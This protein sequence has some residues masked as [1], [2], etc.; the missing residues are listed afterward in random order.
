MPS[1][2][3]PP[4]ERKRD[5]YPYYA[6]FTEDF[7]H[8]VLESY[9][10]ESGSILDPWSGSGTT[11]AA[12]VTQGIAAT[13]VDLN[14][15]LTVMARAR[16]TQRSEAESMGG[17]GREILDLAPATHPCDI[18]ND[19]L[20]L[21]VR[22]ESLR[23]IRSLQGAIHALSGQPERPPKV[24]GA[25]AIPIEDWNQRTCFFYTAL[26]ATVRDLLGHFRATNPTWVR[27]PASPRHRVAPAWHTVSRIFASRIEYLR[28]RLTLVETP[29][30]L[31]IARFTTA[32]AAE[33]PFADAEF[34]G[35]LTSPP[36]ATR[37]DYVKGVLPELAVLG[38]DHEAVEDLRRT[39]LGTP[40]VKGLARQESPL[41]SRTATRLL[42]QIGSHWSKGSAGYYR[43]WM[44]NYL[45]GLEAG[46]MET[47]RSVA[48]QRPICVV[49]QDSH[50]KDLRVDL[51]QIVTEALRSAGRVRVAREDHLV[52]HLRSRMN[53]RA[54][55]HLARRQNSESLLVFQ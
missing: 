30:Q 31:R 2:K 5:W 29:A 34:E 11:A 32:S 35:A 21:W 23:R 17:L 49:V 53:P 22:P 7:A 20:A 16:V 46:L 39:S 48:A 28:E 54:R 47:A 25:S 6:G 50:Y 44:A 1:P 51:Q 37:I 52:R 12:S 55:R 36:Y 3:Q 18:P 40:V 26:F 41:R 13:G 43:P 33:L 24:G 27:Q 8:R 42:R 10:R 45:A 14:P 9:L 4:G 38:L 15:A 19:P